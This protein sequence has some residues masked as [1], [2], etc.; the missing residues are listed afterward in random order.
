M[1]RIISAVRIL[2]PQSGIQCGMVLAPAQMRK[3]VSLAGNKIKSLTGGNLLD[4]GSRSRGGARGPVQNHRADAWGGGVPGIPR[5]LQ[6]RFCH[7]RPGRARPGDQV[8]GAD[9]FLSSA[10]N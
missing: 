7:V 2:I 1:V 10:C 4:A 3:T 9:V 5:L 8:T 6:C